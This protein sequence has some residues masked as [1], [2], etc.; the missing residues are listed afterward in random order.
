MGDRLIEPF[1]RICDLHN[2]VNK[3][4]GKPFISWIDSYQKY[5]QLEPCDN[6]HD[7]SNNSL[8]D[9]TN[10][11]SMSDSVE[12]TFVSTKNPSLSRRL[13]SKISKRK[14]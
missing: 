2:M 11:L 12:V 6:C 9:P 7:L 8:N 4:L 13:N 1:I 14:Y 5:H 3:K 10:N